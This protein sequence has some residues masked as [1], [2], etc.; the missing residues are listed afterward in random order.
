MS[1]NLQRHA[2]SMLFPSK[3]NHLSCLSLLADLAEAPLSTGV[4][5]SKSPLVST[6]DIRTPMPGNHGSPEIEFFRAPQRDRQSS[7]WKEDWEEL[8]LLVGCV[9]NC[10]VSPVYHAF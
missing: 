4:A 5:I 1:P 3:K 10:L 2:L 8:E 9:S 7:R 6:Y